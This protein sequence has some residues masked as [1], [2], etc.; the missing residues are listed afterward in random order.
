MVAKD[1]FFFDDPLHGGDDD[2]W[3]LA[4]VFRDVGHAVRYGVVGV[5][6][7]GGNE[8]TRSGERVSLVGGEYG[9]GLSG[10]VGGCAG[11]SFEAYRVI[12]SSG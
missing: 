12:R 2:W 9:G 11:S 8:M 1:E 3:V 5:V 4:D 6:F 7:G 10:H